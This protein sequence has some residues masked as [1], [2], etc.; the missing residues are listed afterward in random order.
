MLTLV[1]ELLD[2]GLKWT[3]LIWPI[4]YL[5]RYNNNFQ[6]PQKHPALVVKPPL[7]KPYLLKLCE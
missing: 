4:K 7:V 3:F 5:R 6:R 2:L 1:V